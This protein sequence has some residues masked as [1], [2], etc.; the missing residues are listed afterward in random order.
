MKNIYMTVCVSGLVL[1][2]AVALPLLASSSS[3]GTVPRQYAQASL[4]VP[5]P[6]V[7]G[8]AQAQEAAAPAP[9]GSAWQVN[10]TGSG[11]VPVMHCTLFQRVP[12]NQSGRRLL[13]LSIE[14]LAGSDHEIL[15]LEMPHGLRLDQGARLAVDDGGEIILPIT[16]SYRQGVYARTRLSPELLTA[17]KRGTSLRIVMDTV[18]G[19]TVT[20]KMS[21]IGFSAA[22]AIYSGGG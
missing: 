20:I 21:L 4:S 10:C 11:A 5:V 3:M 16:R 1:A 13:R 22:H 7:A 17:L 19:S 14:R 18:D 9:D 15:R 2:G 6:D 8:A 12:D